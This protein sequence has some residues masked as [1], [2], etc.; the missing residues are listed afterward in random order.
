ML[1]G[2]QISKRE[3]PVDKAFFRMIDF[4]RKKI[5]LLSGHLEIKHM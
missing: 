2:S 3:I 1:N 4:D 5:Y